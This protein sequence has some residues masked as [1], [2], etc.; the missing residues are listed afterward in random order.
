M[1]EF[2]SKYK[3]VVFAGILILNLL[4]KSYQLGYNGLWY[5]ECFSVNVAKDDVASIIKTSETDPNP[6]L[7]PILLHYWMK[8]FGDSEFS[9]RFLTVMASAFSAGF[10]FLFCF[11]F[12][13]WQTAIFASLMFF[14]SNEYYYYGQEA[15]TFSVVLLCVILSNYFYLSLINKPD[16]KSCILL[17]VFSA[18]LFYLHYVACFNVVAQ[19]LLFPIVGS[20]LFNEEG[21]PQLKYGFSKKVLAY[22]ISSGLLLLLLLLPFKKRVTALFAETTSKDYK[23]FLAKPSYAEFKQTI[24]DLFNSKAL[25]QTYIYVAI[26][27]LLLFII[28]KKL[29]QEPLNLRIFIFAIAIGPGLIYLIYEMAAYSPFFLKRYVLFTFAGFIITFSYLFSLIKIDFRVKLALFLILS[30]FSFRAMT[31]PRARYQDYDLAV[32][33][34]KDLQKDKRIMVTTDAHDIYSYYFDRSILY[35]NSVDEKRAALFK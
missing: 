6:P 9:I 35:L 32:A 24:Y 17:A 29:R 31:Y 3:Y 33:F 12:L 5:D 30:V 19:V 8:A 18:C 21:R 28:V 14:T 16:L 27:L 15:R 34:F 23:S 26:A 11:R 10:L 7:Y 13:N 25:Y 1:Q 4:F 22:Y 20:R 2:F